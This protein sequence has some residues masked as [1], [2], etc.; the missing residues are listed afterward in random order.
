VRQPGDQQGWSRFVRLYTP[1][2][3]G[4][5]RRLGLA[6]ADAADLVQEVFTHLVR[7][8]PAF[9]YDRQKRFRGWLWTVTLNVYRM[10]RRRAALP[11]EPND[12][13][14][15]TAAVPDPAEGIDEAD[16]RQY[17]V[18][19]AL[20]LMQVEFS[21]NTWQAFLESTTTGDSAAAVAAR[22]GI[23]VCAVYSAKSRVLHHLRQDLAGLLD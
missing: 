6:D 5:A 4:W 11:R 1:L 20:Q 2:L 23:T 13:A 9:R 17:L 7:Q 12:N 14:L 18:G 10:G 22:L 21:P 3:F 8:L 19:R 15:C 16:Y